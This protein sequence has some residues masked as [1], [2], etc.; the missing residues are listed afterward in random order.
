MK[1]YF[2]L[3][4]LS[5]ALLF[6]PRDAF[7]QSAAQRTPQPRVLVF[8]A[9]N[10]EADHALFAIDALKFLTE[11][12]DKDGFRLEATTNWQDMNEANLKQYKLV[13]WLDTAPG[14]AAQKAAF[15][16][17]MEN[18]G[19]WL[20]FHVAAYNDKNSHWP[21]FMTFIGNGVFDVNSWPPVPAK[22]V[23]DDPDSPITKNLPKSFMAPIN[24]WYRWKPSPRLD[25]NIHVLLT[26]DPS[27]FPLGIKGP[28]MGGD[29][30]VVWT[31]TNY[32]MVYMNMGH[33]DKIFTS[34]V[35][36]TLIENSV[37]WLLDK[38]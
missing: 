18:G 6:S 33:G 35:Q 27:N 16:K 37:L 17:Y 21:W 8:L 26:L 31:N 20:G 15:Q 32:K 23:V 4:A 13:L 11:L 14:G 7:A 1:K 29:I 34:P 5:I 9:L 12:A 38:H 24:E 22:L 10:V 19:A 28:V 36:N 2:L 3:M 30:P 25:K